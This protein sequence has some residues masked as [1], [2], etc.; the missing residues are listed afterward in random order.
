MLLGLVVVSCDKGELSKEPTNDI[1]SFQKQSSLFNYIE[2]TH[3]NNG[4]DCTNNILIFPTWDK[5]W[6][7]IDQLDQ[8]IDN[9]C[10]AF[11]ATVPNGISDDDYDALADAAGFDEDNV[12]RKFEEDLEFCSLR[13]KIESLENN[14]LDQQGDGEWDVNAD[15]DNHF[16]DDETERALLSYDAEV[17]IGNKK[18]GFVYYKFLDDEGNYIEVHNGDN[19]A[20]SQVSQGHIPTNNPNVVVQTP[21]KDE[22]TG[23]CKSKVKEV[24]YE[25]DIANGKRLKRISKIRREFGANYTSQTAIFKSKIKAKT[26]GYRKKNGRWRARRTWITAGIGGQVVGEPGLAYNAC[27][28]AL[29]PIYKQKER[30]RRR[31]KVKTTISPFNGALPQLQYLSVLE[32]SLFSLHKQGDVLIINKDFYGMPVN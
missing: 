16:I 5:Y 11:D 24:S 32:N 28:K 30:R 19:E 18:D 3:I 17:I 8:M 13:K 25:Y 2:S 31:V 6:E 22:T 20:I 7:T 12:L 27:D 23:Q 10:D 15:P 21:V 4:S 9:D 14:W 26:K 1:T 29:D